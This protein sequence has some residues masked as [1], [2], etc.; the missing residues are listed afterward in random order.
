MAYVPPH[1]FAAGA[2]SAANVQSNLKG[3][4]DYMGGGMVGGDLAADWVQT[5]HIMRPAYSG[6][7]NVMTFVTGVQGGQSRTIEE[8]TGTMVTRWNTA[9]TAVS[10]VSF[11]D[12]PRNYISNA[13]V[14]IDV[15][16]SMEVLQ[17]QYTIAPQT[18]SNI[19]PTPSAATQTEV[20]LYVWNEAMSLNNITTGAGTRTYSRCYMWPEDSGS[21]AAS[22][23]FNRK[24][25]AGVV[26][27]DA[28]A[29]GRWYIG[30]V[31]KS[32][33]FYTK[34]LR[35]TISVEG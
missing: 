8:S 30:L 18:T 2:L 20:L 12:A 23:Q 33:C 10:S 9:R 17:V 29:A 31:G 11:A 6:I 14:E 7:K 34:L 24:A 5:R 32:D 27:I 28:P 26:L 4:Q 19:S 21:T 13:A 22:Q 35:W 25:G 15:P 3:V 16:R 1:T